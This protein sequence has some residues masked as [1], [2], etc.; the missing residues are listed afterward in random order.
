MSTENV[1]LDRVRKL[2]AQAEDP[3]VTISEA[4]AFTAKAAALMAKYGIDRAL[5]GALQP[6]TDQPAD[7]I[8][9]IPNPWAAVYGHLLCGLAG[10]MRCQPVSI[11]QK[12]GAKIHLFGYASDLE[13]AELLYTSVLLQLRHGLARTT[14][15]DWTRS[16]QAWRR[17]WMLGYCT[18]VI[19][20]VRAAE[21]Q[22]A[23]DA[24]TARPAAGQTAALVLASREQVISGNV[25]AVY[26]LTRKS[27]ITYSGSGYR[28]GYQQ[29]ARADIGA[30]RVT[31]QPRQAIR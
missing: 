3:A 28:D 24:D 11:S 8:I 22:A 26:P 20:R 25:K 10:A 6:E 5:L 29:G 17:S 2:L 18:A 21:K 13:R 19:G 31:Q 7:R 14:V 23:T 16:P 4:E 12:S 15:P 27:K 30:T 1:M 9:T